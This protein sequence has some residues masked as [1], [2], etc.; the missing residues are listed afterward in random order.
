M[1]NVS[2][3]PDEGRARYGVLRGSK[4]I[5]AALALLLFMAFLAGCKVVD[6]KTLPPF[7]KN[8]AAKDSAVLIIPS[9]AKVNRIDGRK[10]GLFSS[11]SPG[12]ARTAT[13]L[14]PAGEH[15]I[16]CGYVDSAAGWSAKKLKYT[17]KMSA[18]KQYLVSVTRD[19][20]TKVGMG[21]LVLNEATSF[22]RDQ[23]IDNIPFVEWLPR[24]NPE[25]VV[26]RIN[27]IDRTM[28][29]RYLLETGVAAAEKK[30]VLIGLLASLVAFIWLCIILV[31]HTV[32][33][34]VWLGK[35][36]SRYRAASIVFRAVMAAA[37]MIIINYNS[38]GTL[39]LYLAATVLLSIA[40]PYSMGDDKNKSGLDKLENKKDYAGAIADFDDAISAGPYNAVYFYNR[41]LAYC[42]L[43][44]WEHALADFS[45]A[46]SLS[47]KNETFKKHLAYAK[48]QVGETVA[49]MYDE[50]AE[51]ARKI[52][53]SV[54][55]R[56]SGHTSKSK[57]E[58]NRRIARVVCIVTGVAL[59]VVGIG[60]LAA[61][62]EMLMTCLGLIVFGV[63]L[64]VCAV[65]D[66]DGE[67]DMGIVVGGVAGVVLWIVLC[68]L[69]KSSS[70]SFSAGFIIDK[71]IG[72]GF[73]F[74]VVGALI[75]AVTYVIATLML[76]H[77]GIP[78]A[79]A[80]ALVIAT[81][82]IGRSVIFPASTPAPLEVPAAEA[83]LPQAPVQADRANLRSMPSVDSDIVKTLK[84]GDVLTVTGDAQ[85]GW[86]PVE[87]NGDNG[88]I[89]A[90]LVTLP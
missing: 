59:A 5:G 74:S 21:F 13:V 60:I 78:V 90:E 50:A 52:P 14:V 20:K 76:V 33:C 2:T 81:L 1:L 45:Q 56:R 77:W 34:F 46:V 71:G 42:G 10:R 69:T 80:A 82:Y 48:S 15:T 29:D 53:A 89:S 25:G 44:D 70:V 43:E 84:K 51:A 30:P 83:V 86:L 32:W 39:L 58:W 24:P 31:L 66:G 3:G 85:N 8:A 55:K 37:G 75:G 47:P 18:G 36:E 35:F 68:V 79:V 72:G 49:A 88:Y 23:I 4:R 73:I 62:G 40:G 63:T 12:S 41:G 38:G 22:M 54:Y 65:L 57:E 64:V 67:F 87:H 27:E 16:L 28:L 7:D 26:F 61:T 9:G 17:V 6:V 11:W 19:E